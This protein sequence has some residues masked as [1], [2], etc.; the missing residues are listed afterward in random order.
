MAKK[1]KVAVVLQSGNMTADLIERGERLI[2]MLLQRDREILER[3]QKVLDKALDMV[4]NELSQKG[5][6]QLAGLFQ[7]IVTEFSKRMAEIVDLKKLQAMS[8]GMKRSAKARVAT[9]GKPA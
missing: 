1:A 8:P 6:D 2:M 5:N 7:S 9:G 3:K 4:Q